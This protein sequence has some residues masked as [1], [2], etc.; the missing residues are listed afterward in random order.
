MALPEALTDPTRTAYHNFVLPE[1][2][3]DRDIWGAYLNQNIEG[4]DRALIKKGSLVE[5]PPAAEAG[6]WYM[7]TDTDPP[8]IYL[9][10]GATWETV[11]NGSVN[12]LGG[13]PASAYPRKAENA[14]VSGEW[15]FTA[16]IMHNYP[17]EIREHTGRLLGAAPAPDSAAYILLCFADAADARVTGQIYGYRASSTATSM[18]DSIQIVLGSD[19]LQNFEGGFTRYRGSADIGPALRLVRCTYNNSDYIALEATPGTAAE[20]YDMALTFSGTTRRASFNV[21]GAASVTNVTQP[22]GL[23]TAGNFEFS[24][25]GSITGD[26]SVSQTLTAKDMVA[27]TL[28]LGPS[29]SGSLSSG[30]LTT[31]QLDANFAMH[32]NDITEAYTLPAG[33][34]SVIAGELSG[35]GSI[36]GDGSLAVVDARIHKAIINPLDEPLDAAGHDI[37]NAGTVT[38][39]S[40]TVTN[41]VRAGLFHTDP[42]DVRAITTPAPGDMAYHDGTGTTNTEGPAFYHSVGEWR[43]AVDGSTIS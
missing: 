11:W 7:A 24:G 31:N 26:F 22:A 38:A 35:T 36:T 18:P 12:E 37:Q 41:D 4:I 8:S 10:T 27:E 42:R 30:S 40:A 19:S 5:R 34:G 39:G 16:P 43:S 14:T 23:Q 21:V 13:F 17:G 25:V 6:R 28:T 9:D 33:K 20:N 1:E 32:S 29:G 3:G 15:S 2:G